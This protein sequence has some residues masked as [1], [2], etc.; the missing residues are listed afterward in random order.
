MPYMIVC[1]FIV[2]IV[3][4]HNL[5]ARLSQSVHVMRFSKYILYLC[6]EIIKSSLNVSKIIWSPRMAIN[7]SVKWIDAYNTVL[8][9]A[10]YANSITL[11][12]GTITVATSMDKLLIHALNK[13]SIKELEQREMEEKIR[14]VIC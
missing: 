11:T 8:P 5:H 12:P 9:N 2:A 13:I 14:S 10:I 3:C 6:I 4:I 1:T 7:P